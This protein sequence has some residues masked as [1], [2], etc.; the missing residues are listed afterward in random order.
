MN[1]TEGEIYQP[2][3]LLEWAENF[4]SL[5]E[6]EI[7]AH[8]NRIHVIPVAQFFPIHTSL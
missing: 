6:P 2:D 8:A 1:F 3:F 4:G 7:S 5:R